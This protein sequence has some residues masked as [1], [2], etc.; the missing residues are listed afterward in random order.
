[1]RLTQPTRNYD[2]ASG[3]GRRVTSLQPLS[4]ISPCLAL[5]Q[6]G[7]AWPPALLPTPVVSYTSNRFRVLSSSITYY[8]PFHPYQDGKAL[9]GGLFLWPDPVGRPTPGVTRH[10]TL[11]SADFPQSRKR[12]RSPDQPGYWNDKLI[13]VLRQHVQFC[14][15]KGIR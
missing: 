5:L 3:T 12:S 14:W 4:W 9:P 2:P 8:P 7:V 15:T 6:M 11:W 13:L 10:L 1:M